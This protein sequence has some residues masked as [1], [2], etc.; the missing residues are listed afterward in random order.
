MGNYFLERAK[1]V[2]G[3]LI[4]GIMTAV[5]HAVEQAFNF[6]LGVESETS[7]I[8]AVTGLLVY[9]TPNKAQS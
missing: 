7:I 9:Q 4:P 2:M 3:F 5:I 1:A 6:D 8:M